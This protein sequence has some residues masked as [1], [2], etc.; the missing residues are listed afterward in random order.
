VTVAHKGQ[1]YQTSNFSHS[2][3]NIALRTEHRTPH[4]APGTS[5]LTSTLAFKLFAWAKMLVA[6]STR[7][8]L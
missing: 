8:V 7:E 6:I 3:Q 4:L 5:L 1:G 2:A